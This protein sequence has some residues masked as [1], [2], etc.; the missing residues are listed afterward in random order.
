M[1]VEKICMGAHHDLHEDVMEF[2]LE[3]KISGEEEQD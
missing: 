2:I 3:E 1:E